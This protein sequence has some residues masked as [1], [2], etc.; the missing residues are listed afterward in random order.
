[1]VS[2]KTDAQ[3]EEAALR[4]ENA[5]GPTVRGRREILPSG[6]SDLPLQ[7]VAEALASAGYVYIYDTVTRERSL[8]NRNLLKAALGKKRPGGGFYFTTL[9]PLEPPKRGVLKCYL[10]ADQ[11]EWALYE[12]MGYAACDKHNLNTVYDQRQHMRAKHRREWAAIEESRKLLQEAETLELQ[13]EVLKALR[14]R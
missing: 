6:D 10:H 7:V 14:D 2:T 4:A 13:R 5:P 12:A 1:M 11:P 8:I 9:E 3:I